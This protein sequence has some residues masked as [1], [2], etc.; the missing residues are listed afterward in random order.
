MRFVA[1]ALMFAAG[2]LVGFGVSVTRA[3]NQAHKRY[4]ESEEYRRRAM[5]LA[6]RFA[7]ARTETPQPF[8]TQPEDVVQAVEEWDEA[9]AAFYGL[10]PKYGAEHDNSTGKIELITEDE[11]DDENGH[12]KHQVSVMGINAVGSVDCL[13]DGSDFNDHEETL[14]V[15]LAQHMIDNAI[16]VLYVRN[17]ETLEDFEVFLETP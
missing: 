3:E 12:E 13:L 17:T 7:E 14:G 1:G 16:D 9:T 2:A 15:G 10:I 5:E 4:S 6:A 8:E 11:F